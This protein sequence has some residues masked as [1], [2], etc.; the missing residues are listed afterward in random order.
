[1]LHLPLK[2]IWSISWIFNPVLNNLQLGKRP[3]ETRTGTE[4][5][6]GRNERSNRVEGEDQEWRAIDRT[7][8]LT[9]KFTFSL[10]DK[11]K[12]RKIW[13]TDVKGDQTCRMVTSQSTHIHHKQYPLEQDS[14]FSLSPYQPPNNSIFFTFVYKQKNTDNFIHHGTIF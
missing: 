9:T 10:H 6:G 11:T 1:M 14:C 13:L 7:R 8:S 12:I 3:S 2:P 4:S 5:N